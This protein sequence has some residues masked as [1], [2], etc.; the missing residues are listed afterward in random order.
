MCAMKPNGMGRIE[1]INK[2]RP[3]TGHTMWHDE[4]ATNS[5]E[6]D[7][8]RGGR[9]EERRR[10]QLTTHIS[11]LGVIHQ[12]SKPKTYVLKWIVEEYN[13]RCSCVSPTQSNSEFTTTATDKTVICGCGHKVSW[14]ESADIMD[15]ASQ[16]PQ[17]FPACSRDT[18]CV[19]LGF[20]PWGSPPGH[21]RLHDSHPALFVWETGSHEV[22]WL[23]RPAGGVTT[24]LQLQ[25]VGNIWHTG[26]M[27]KAC[28]ENLNCCI[29]VVSH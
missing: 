15:T 26:N 22:K 14:S 21:H 29:F 2:T 10:G 8:E 1:Q 20:L 11:E 7:K 9:E 25:D 17:F 23:S 16:L 13:V 6:K 12:N 4:K 3:Y 18:H 27:S 5:S 24:G 28:L 19:G